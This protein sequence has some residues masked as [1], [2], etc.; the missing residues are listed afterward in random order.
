MNFD[1]DKEDWVFAAIGVGLILFFLTLAGCE[2]KPEKAETVPTPTKVEREVKVDKPSKI[3][4]PVTKSAPVE[5][6]VEEPSWWDFKDVPEK[7]YERIFEG[8]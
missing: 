6:E 1:F 5:K 3:N 7:E 8:E 2:N 4:R